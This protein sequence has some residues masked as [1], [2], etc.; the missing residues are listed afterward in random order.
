MQ[1]LRFFLIP[2]YVSGIIEHKLRV[3]RT[4]LRIICFKFL[5]YRS[6]RWNF[7]YMS[8]ETRAI[9]SFVLDK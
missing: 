9:E 7:A 8:Q 1:I 3:A 4:R 2:K 6:G 5:I